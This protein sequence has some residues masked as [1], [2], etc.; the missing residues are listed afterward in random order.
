VTSAGPVDVGAVERFPDGRPT[1]LQVG[2]R[3][4]GIVNWR[5]RFYAVRNVCAHMGARLCEGTVTARVRSD[6]PTSPIELDDGEAPLINC[7]WHGWSYDAATGESVVDP[8]RFRV[9][10]YPVTVRAGRVLVDLAARQRPLR[11]VGHPSE[12]RRPAPGLVTRRPAEA[13][14]APGTARC[15]GADS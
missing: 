11:H 12:D 1:V 14:P 15:P 3:E 8:R 4:L 6:G 13:A 2:G 5:G 10:T 9:R 7:P